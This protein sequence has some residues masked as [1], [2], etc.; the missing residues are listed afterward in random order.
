MIKQI[1]S[2]RFLV[3]SV[4]IILAACTRAL[5]RLLP[6]MWNFTAVGA[7]AVFAG[8]RIA[9]KKLAI[10]VPL[11]AMVLSDL[12]IGGDFT[13]PV[14]YAAFVC[15]VICGILIKDKVSVTNVALASIAGAVIF[16]LIT[17]FAF[18]YPWYPHNMQGVMQSYIAGLPFLRNMLIA[19]AFYGVV[20]FGGFYLLERKYPAISAGRI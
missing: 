3:L 7:L 11:A 13:R 15:M 4:L 18:L 20:L 17:N 5:P 12:F 14:V 2:S 6:D 9:D 10:I 19:D 8:A 16:Y 1:Q